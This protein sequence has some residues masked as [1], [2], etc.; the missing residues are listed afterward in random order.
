MNRRHTWTLVTSSN[1]SFVSHNSPVIPTLFYAKQQQYCL[2]C[3]ESMNDFH[4][5][6][7]FFYSVLLFYFRQKQGLQWQ[8]Q[9][10]TTILS[11]SSHKQCHTGKNLKHTQQP[12]FQSNT[13]AYIYITALPKAEKQ[14]LK[15]ILLYYIPQRSVRSIHVWLVALIYHMNSKPSFYI[16]N[17]YPSWSMFWDLYINKAE[18]STPEYFTKL[19][20]FSNRRQGTHFHQSLTIWPPL[21]EYWAFAISIVI[22]HQHL[23]LLRNA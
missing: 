11:N 9:L 13:W 17:W 4:N 3:Q 21:M 1:I 20:Y 19:F 15:S 16:I 7:L 10:Y 18:M 14:A 6:V 5:T 8:Q 23:I 2:W 22:L 12:M